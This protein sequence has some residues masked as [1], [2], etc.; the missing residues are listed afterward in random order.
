MNP[1]QY[2]Y[3]PGPNG[4]PGPGP[5]GNPAQGPT[6]PYGPPGPY[7]AQPGYGGAPQQPPFGQQPP[8]PGGMPAGPQNN[9][10]FGY[11]PYPYPG[12]Y[13]RAP[14]KKPN[15]AIFIIIGG[16]VLLV[17]IVVV[18]SLSSNGNNQNNTQQPTTDQ[19][20]AKT[21]KD[22]EP[23]DDNQLDLSVRAT[24]SKS[25]KAQTVKGSSQQQLNLSSGFSFMV[26][27]VEA[28][29]SSN[30]ATVPAAGKKFI[31]VTAVVGNRLDS[32]NI[33]VSYLDFRLRDPNNVAIAPNGTAT[34]ELLNNPLA[35][36]S[37]L[38]P[39]QQLTGK[40]VFEV[41]ATDS[42]WVFIHSETYQK[43]TDDTT[44]S[45]EG[46]IVVNQSTSGA[47]TPTATPPTPTPTS[48]SGT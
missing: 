28:Y 9:P 19:S 40:L 42:N 21:V 24:L 31:V 48:A 34:N 1:Q 16:A 47:T 27:K 22:V 13:D 37:E 18:A 32:G 36:P 6:S 43:T 46:Q 5:Q 45:V 14:R 3:Q 41:D 25:L 44:F 15:K 12:E 20:T 7:P 29:T 38:K 8:V 17:V 4:Q 11:N 2:P 35:S 23:R 39:G 30:A 33:S 26:T 10:A